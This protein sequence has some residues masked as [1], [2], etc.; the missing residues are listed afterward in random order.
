M[1]NFEEMPEDVPEAIPEIHPEPD[2]HEPKMPPSIA[3]I[4]VDDFL[5]KNEDLDR[6]RDHDKPTIH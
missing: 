5:E 3:E 1:P 6:K 2:T 4:G